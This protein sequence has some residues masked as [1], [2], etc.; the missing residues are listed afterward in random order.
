MYVWKFISHN[1]LSLSSLIARRIAF[2]RERTFSKF[3][4]R[5]ALTATALSVAIMILATALVNGFQRV[6][7]HKVFS[8]WG[9]IHIMEYQ[10]NASPLT[11]EVPFQSNDTL[12]GKIAA[13]PG[14]KSID[15]YAT[16]SAILKTTNE[17]EGVIFKGVAPGYHWQ[18]LQPYLINGH[19]LQ[20]PDS[21][22]SSQII[23][24]AYLARKLNLKVK[25]GVIVYFIQK[26]GELPRPRK[27]II[28]GIYKT[29]IEE[30][31][32]TFV[33]GDLRLIRLLNGWSHG[34]IG[35]YEIFLRNYHQMD[36]ISNQIF[37]KY[38]PQQL[39][40]QTIRQV[41]PNIFD[42]LR[43]QNTNEVIIILIMTLVAVI[44][45]TTAILILILERTHMVGILKALGMK[46]RALQGV[47]IIQAGYIAA[48]GIIMGNIVGLGLAFLQ[49]STGFFKLNESTYYMPVAPIDIHGWEVLAID[50]GTLIVCLV[51]L[52]IP[53]ELIRRIGSVQ[54]IG[55]K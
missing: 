5:I 1:I 53:S 13:I 7:S 31:D 8:F 40:T 30:Y 38:L 10:P 44:N 28:A 27:L 55:F 37:E 12:E 50:G 51:I 29:S 14:V 52:I 47:F 4:I 23:I 54:A 25:D 48:A 34:Q 32:R 24:S 43:L 49:K 11:E 2:N 6:V 35:G 46:N 15:A 16:K 33:I 17:I 36:T 9:H 19:V 45:M 39:T 42:W 21:G 26:A 18:N 22:Y 41:Y 3:I 20:F